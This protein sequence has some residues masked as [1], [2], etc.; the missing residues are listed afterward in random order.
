MRL[1]WAEKLVETIMVWG[2]HGFVDNDVV[3]SNKRIMLRHPKVF[4]GSVY[5]IRPMNAA[6]VR[7]SIRHNMYW[8]HEIIEQRGKTVK[9]ESNAAHPNSAMLS[10]SAAD[11]R[12]LVNQITTLADD[13]VHP[14]V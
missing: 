6:R 3:R 4:H 1:G 8:N 11:S 10:C 12:S 14:V 9:H 5:S 2:D 13:I 7:T